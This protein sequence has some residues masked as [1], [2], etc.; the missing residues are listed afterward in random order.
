MLTNRCNIRKNISCQS[1]CWLNLLQCVAPYS[2]E[3]RYRYSSIVISIPGTKF[4]R[5]INTHDHDH[6]CMARETTAARFTQHKSERFR[7]G[8]VRDSHM[9]TRDQL[10]SSRLL[11]LLHNNAAA[12][13]GAPEDV[14]VCLL[15]TS[16]SP[17]DRTRSRMPSSA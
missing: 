4:P 11:W 12:G 13:S 14:C 16:P 7:K 17:R 2:S 1:T 10:Q 5:K 6:I 15:Y 8:P 3:G 9:V